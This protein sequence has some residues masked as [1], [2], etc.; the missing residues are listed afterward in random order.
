MVLEDFIPR[1]KGA[2]ILSSFDRIQQRATDFFR[3]NPI[4]SS[5]AIGAGTS[6]L[7]VAVAGIRKVKKRKKAKKRTK[8]RTKK[9]TTR[10]RKTRKTT[11]KRKKVTHR[12]PRHSGHKRVTFTTKDGKKVSFLVAKKGHTHKRRKRKKCS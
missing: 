7:V 2:N 12:S 6:G 5:A 9:K 11:K 10:K 8:K 3:A 1:L 4:L